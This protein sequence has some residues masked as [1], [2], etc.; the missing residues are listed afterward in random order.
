MYFCSMTKKELFEL[1]ESN[2]IKEVAKI[3]KLEQAIWQN[4]L[5]RISVFASIIAVLY[6]FW[7]WEGWLLVPIVIGIVL[8]LFLVRRQLNLDYRKRISVE[9]KDIQEEEIRLL[10]KNY[11]D[12]ATGAEFA[13]VD[14]AYC[15]DVDLF[16]KGSFYHYINRT[17]LD[18][19][20]GELAKILLSND[21]D[22]IVEKQEVVAEL[23]KLVAWRH[24]YSAEAGLVDIEQNVSS[25]EEWMESYE[26]F[27]PKW[28]KPLIIGFSILSLIVILLY[29]LTLIPEGI[30]ILWLFVGI[31][32]SG[33]FLKKVN[34]LQNDTSKSLSTFQ[35]YSKLLERIEARSWSAKMIGDKIDETSV[36]GLQASSSI[37]QF[38]KLL[39]SL[40]Q[41]TNIMISIFTNGFF[42]RDLYIVIRIEDWIEQ[43]RQYVKDWFELVHFFETYN[44]LGNFA[45]NHPNYVF[46]EISTQARKG[47]FDSQEL[48]HPLLDESKRIDNDFL[49]D[50]EAF[51]IVTGAN[52]AGK[53]TFLRTVSLAV[54]MSNMGLPVCA[55]RI[56]YSPTKL[57]TSMRTSDSLS[58][59]ASYFYAELS[60]LRY[61]IDLLEQDD[62]FI[63][64]DEILKGTN[65]VDK[66]TGSKKFV[67]RLIG[68]QSTGII[69]THD[70]SLCKIADEHDEVSNYYFDAKIID[71]E[72]HFDYTLK[73]GICKNMNASFLLRKMDII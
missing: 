36:E 52:M 5:M 55:Q 61:I 15:Q 69:A 4:S 58:D 17:R 28:M 18:K 67:K 42:L 50:K 22:N 66:A 27:V 33:I 10:D 45:F 59:E 56:V 64:L 24:D 29:I 13:L 31:F 34:A 57:V 9:R 14:H 47:L 65:S 2:R 19:A 68:T 32:I 63:I 60:R 8:F 44:S 71:D 41:R 3:E 72:L 21:T 35:Q 73:E 40:D 12:E 25:I 20:S 43:N 1:Y 6:F 62:Y 51:Y 30:A 70:L 48:G 16:G 53:S 23:S 38:G 54:I 39:N 11:K 26:R 7:N 49:I 37:K 46:P